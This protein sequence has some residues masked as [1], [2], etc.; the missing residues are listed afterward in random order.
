MLGWSLG[1]DPDSFSLWHSSQYPKGFN[2]IAYQNPQVDDWLRQGRALQDRQA[3]K[4]VYQALYQTL[5]AELP[6]LFLYYP[7]TLSGIQ[8]RVQGLAAPGPAGLMNPIEA[9]FLKD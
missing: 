4:T 6:Y 9:I 7:E 2:F 1:L 5:A 8:S 3:R